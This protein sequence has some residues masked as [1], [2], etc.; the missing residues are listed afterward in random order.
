MRKCHECAPTSTRSDGWTGG[1]SSNLSQEPGEPRSHAGMQTIAGRERL[2]AER[3]G[4]PWLGWRVDRLAPGAPGGEC[5]NRREGRWAI[6]RCEMRNVS[7]VQGRFDLGR[8]SASASHT[9]LSSVGRISPAPCARAN[10]PASGCARLP[11]RQASFP[12]RPV[13]QRASEFWQQF[14]PSLHTPSFPRQQ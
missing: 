14:A 2:V 13:P 4:Q 7:C 11:P 12:P 9:E 5:L 8:A 6:E 1:P 10:R 3:G